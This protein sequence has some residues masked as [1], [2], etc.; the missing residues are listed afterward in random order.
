MPFE[1]GKSGNP[2][3]RPKK[4]GGKSTVAFTIKAASG[5]PDMPTETGSKTIFVNN[6][7]G[8]TKHKWVP[9]GTNNLFPNA[10]A[11]MARKSVVHRSIMYHKKNFVMPH[12]MIT[13]NTKLA[14]YIKSVNDKNEPLPV[15]AGK[16]YLDYQANGNG[17][18]EVAKYA[19]KKVM[20]YHKDYTK[21]RVKDVERSKEK[22]PGILFHPD[23]ANVQ[24]TPEKIVEY[25]LYPKFKEIDGA[26]R[27]ILHFKDYEAEFT[28]Y[29]IPLFIAAMDVAAITWKT[30]KWNVSR[31]DNSFQAS[32]VLV[33]EGDYS[34]EDAQELRAAIEEEFTGEDNQGKIFT[35]IKQQGGSSTTWTPFANLVD[36]DWT[37]LHTQ[38]NK[39]LVSAHAWQKS[40]CN[41]SDAAQ[42][43]NTT[44][45]RNEYG[46]ATRII[47]NDQLFF[48]NPIRRV[49]KEQ[50][51]MD[52]D[53]LNFVNISPVPITDLLDPTTVLT[54]TE[55]RRA[56]GY[57]PMTPEQEEEFKTD[58][59]LLNKSSNAN[60]SGTSS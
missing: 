45:I 36:G 27:S 52:A 59:E 18:V 40:L 25:P 21:A 10:L 35:I 16:Y 3:G 24:K 29:G 13:A 55:Q 57:E 56:F 32:G 12:Q 46:L 11:A 22:T 9:F 37:N 38:A 53:D 31:L 5:V 60:N 4:E 51:G 44:L 43:S 34:P 20:F 28:D 33:I 7:Q 48:L 26:Q 42:L 6:S 50:T 30:N 49:I 14:A 17:Y 8:F 47:E 23:W 15:V 41:M 2:L 1:K 39:D 54:R 19:D 58:Q